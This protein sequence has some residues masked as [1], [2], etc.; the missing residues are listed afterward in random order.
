MALLGRSAWKARPPRAAAIGTR[1]D[2]AARP[3]RR[4]AE[5]DEPSTDEGTAWGRIASPWR[6]GRARPTSDPRVDPARD[7]QRS[8][9]SAVRHLSPHLSADSDWHASCSLVQGMQEAAMLKRIGTGRGS[10]GQESVQLPTIDPAHTTGLRRRLARVDSGALMP[11]SGLWKVS[12][13]RESA[14]RAAPSHDRPTARWAITPSVS[15]STSIR[16][17]IS[18]AELLDA[19][20]GM[21]DPTRSAH[22]VQY[23]SLILTHDETQEALALEAARRWAALLG[24]EP[25]HADRAVQRFHARRG[26]PPEVRPASGSR[27]H[28][29]DAPTLSGRQRASGVDCGSQAQRVSVWCGL[30]ASAR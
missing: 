30:T 14:M 24:K 1:E 21:H 16:R 12:C 23:E 4:Q 7:S 3:P 29:A 8:S 28:E 18:Y 15:R 13:A 17:P 19:F 5:T 25:L 11:G 26:L 9:L 22:S 20:F 10:T 27:D 2:T 6:S